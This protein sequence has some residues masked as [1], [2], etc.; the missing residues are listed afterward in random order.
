MHECRPWYNLIAP[1]YKYILTWLGYLIIFIHLKMSESVKKAYTFPF[2]FL[3]NTACF[4]CPVKRLIGTKKNRVT[5]YLSSSSS[6]HLNH[7]IS[8]GSSSGFLSSFPVIPHFTHFFPIHCQVNNSCVCPVQGN[9]SR[10]W[11]DRRMHSDRLTGWMVEFI[12]KIGS[13][14]PSQ[15]MT[16]SLCVYLYMSVCHWLWW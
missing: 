14:Q 5:S 3:F 13:C 12:V 9:L 11:R 8:R 15:L 6:S 1:S 4:T 7:I 2:S 16:Y 10:N